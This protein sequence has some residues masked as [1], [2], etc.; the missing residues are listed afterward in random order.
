[1]EP[2]INPRTLGVRGH[3]DCLP[4]VA[5]DDVAIFKIHTTNCG[6]RMT[7]QGDMLTY[8]VVVES[9]QTDQSP[10]SLQV[11]CMYEGPGFQSATT[12]H[13]ARIITTPAPLV[14][15]GTVRVQ[16]RIA[17]DS[18]FSSFIDG[19]QLPVAFP[20]RSPVYVEVSIRQPAPEPG[21]SLQV[22]DCFAYPASR[23]SV[24]TLL[25]DGCPN[26]LDPLRSSTPVDSQ[27]VTGAPSQVRRF[28]V[29][30]FAFLDPQTG[31][32]SSEEVWDLG[33]YF[34]C[35]VEICTID[36]AQPCTIISSEDKLRRRRRRRR[37][38][39]WSAQVVSLG[40]LQLGHYDTEPEKLQPNTMFQGTLYSLGGILLVVALLCTI[41][42]KVE[43]DRR[44]ATEPTTTKR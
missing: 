15:M 38:E 34:Y 4:V 20:L 39:V 31:Q 10:F 41:Q 30:T 36:C 40:P 11:Q 25:Y 23:T 8:E 3:R 22:R 14:A 19:D 18:S 26:L 29:K 35:W 12:V 32:P 37:G 43:W 28:N 33:I 17:T 13:S 42:Q 5:T 2:R 44:R 21:L 27:G 6:S 24:W 7:L 1:M 9:L 16:M